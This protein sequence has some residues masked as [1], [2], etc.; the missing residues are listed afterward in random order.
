[1]STAA[2]L[3]ARPTTAVSYYFAVSLDGGAT[4]AHYYGQHAIISLG[5]EPRVFQ[6]SA[7][8]RRFGVRRG[9]SASSVTVKLDNTDGELDWICD[10][11]TWVTQFV[12]S[13]WH[14]V[15]YLYDPRNLADFN[16]KPLG[17]F[18]PGLDAPVRT[19]EAIEFTLVDQSLTDM[20]VDDL[21]TVRDWMGI[22][23]ANRPAG[24]SAAPGEQLDASDAGAVPEFSIDAPVPLLFGSNALPVQR[25]QRN[26]YV[27]CSVE[28]SAGA[29]PL[30]LV[31]IR[32]GNGRT[33]GSAD[34]STITTS[35]PGGVTYTLA[36]LRRTPDITKNGRTWHLIWM[37]LDI[38]DEGGAGVDLTALL[39][40]IR[41][42]GYEVD[43]SSD[44]AVFA[45]H[46]SLDVSVQGLLWSHNTDDVT[47]LA[48]GRHAAEV[49]YELLSNYTRQASTLTVDA[50]SFARV[51]AARP[52]SKAS[53]VLA[54]QQL[55]STNFFQ[56]TVNSVVD[57]ELLKT[58]AA[59]CD[60]GDFDI[61]VAWDGTV[62]ATSDFS[63]YTALSATVA[64]LEESEVMAD[65]SERIPD[66]GERGEPY[67]RLFVSVGSQL[68]GPFDDFAAITAWGQVVEARVD[69]SWIQNIYGSGVGAYAGLVLDL[70][71]LW[72]IYGNRDG[73]TVR[74]R[75]TVRTWLNGL[76]LELG[77]LVQFSWSRGTLA[78][79]Y[80][81]AVFRVESIR[82]D[83]MTSVVTLVLA[84]R[85]DLRADGNSP[86]LLDDETLLDRA[87]GSGGR[88]CTL[89]TG[90]NTVSFSSG[91]LVSDGVAAGDHL[92]VLDSTESATSFN[93]NRAL[94]ISSV[95]D[96][97]HL[98]IN[99]TYSS[100]AFGS[101]GPFT[102]STWEI[103]RG[104]L[105]YRV[106]GELYGKVGDSTHAGK[107]SDNA[108][109]AY[110]LIDG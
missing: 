87:T 5:T 38:N 40:V 107:F 99:S 80:T 29:L 56:E 75:L 96:A 92:I 17:V 11:D 42:I 108:T 74:P 43:T 53:G 36:T 58:L 49:A 86:Y 37:D 54:P 19:A 88:T 109:D 10:R 95:T 78:G 94:L 25:V 35:L 79:P 90:S 98:V 7:L 60:T 85:D 66:Q 12:S 67:N 50:T 97:T 101:G 1:M 22:T 46:Y 91:S 59:V 48:Q 89:T 84:W 105:T 110:K 73:S 65:V 39:G 69:G 106:G 55:S 47:T 61:F 83:P 16:T 100:N 9:L 63:D 81:L 28:G 82:L 72:N 21:P 70:T 68:L 33:M 52:T 24:L 77:D 3:L 44:S 76:N 93:R 13:Q 14:L 30:G 23:D 103:R 71:S 41:A 57:G 104:A 62:T 27:V 64:T 31:A 4:F 2:E 51:A 32:F 20:Q 45:S 15:A 6:L 8:E 26:C 102:L 18:R 34:G